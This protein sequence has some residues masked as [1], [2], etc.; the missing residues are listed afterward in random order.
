MYYLFRSHS[1][2]QQYNVYHKLKTDSSHKLTIW[3]TLHWSHCFCD[4]DLRYV[5]ASIIP[6]DYSRY[7]CQS[8][9]YYYILTQKQ[10][11]EVFYEKRCSW[12]FLKIHR[13]TAM[14]QPLFYKAVLQICFIKPQA[15]NFIK[16]ETLA[17]VFSYEFCEISQNSFF[18]E[19][20]W[21]TA[22]VKTY[23]QFSWYQSCRYETVLTSSSNILTNFRSSFLFH[24]S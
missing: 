11:P 12:K 7:R 8:T 4:Q 9:R 5:C 15:C 3:L 14:P 6:N 19:H 16:K 21:T 24:T 17:L 18:T 20:L 13:K 23:F 10:P 1:C 22:S 2:N